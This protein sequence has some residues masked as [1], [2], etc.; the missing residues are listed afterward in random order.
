MLLQSSLSIAAIYLVYHIFLRKDTF[1][2][3]NRFYLITAILFS[4]LIPF[5]D[6]S[7]LFGPIEKTYFVLLDPIIIYPEGVQ[8]T[9]DNN[10]SI[11]QIVMAIY[12]TG[13][14]IFL[15]RFLFQLVQ[16]TLLIRRYGISKM[17]GMRFVFT[18]KTYSPFSFFN[19]V[20]LN[21][22]DLESIDTQKIIAHEKVHIQQW[23][24]LDL[25]LLEIITIIQWFNPFIWMYR[26]A[27]KTLHEYLA[28]EGVLY[29]GVD[30]KVYSALL[31]SQSTGIQ[32]NDLANNFNKSLLKRRFIM[33]TKSRTQNF[34]RLKLMFVL[35][36]AFSMLLVISCGPDVPTQQEKEVVKPQTDAPN[37]ADRPPPPLQV[38]EDEPKKIFTVV[39]VM[40]EYPGGENEMMKFLAENI[41]YPTAAKENGISGKVYV[42]FIVDQNGLIGDITILRGIGAGC[43]EEAMRV[44]KMMPKWKPGTQ[45]GQAVR[46]QYNLPIKFTLD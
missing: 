19:I 32:I 5:L 23:H 37:E 34:A 30:V 29:S 2:K 40:P 42:T 9:L 17:Q 18:D 16:L 27:I 20:F 35:P 4:L 44:I 7:R 25:M 28:D 33:M 6:L 15:F 39:E 3:T 36:L 1:F 21:R 24:S 26:H 22:S 11:F 45:R 41:K 43:D 46:V 12:F 31:F 13:V 8:A 14:I 10:P 38:R